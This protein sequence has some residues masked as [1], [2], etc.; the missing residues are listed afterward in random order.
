MVSAAFPVHIHIVRTVIS[1]HSKG[2]SKALVLAS[3]WTG[4]LHVT[5]AVLGTFVLKRFPTSF[6]IGF[7]LGFLVIIA[8]QNLILFG[9]FHGYSLGTGRTNHIFS[10]LALTLFLVLSFFT[11][12]LMNFRDFLVVAAVD[13]KGFGR[14]QQ[15]ADGVFGDE[16]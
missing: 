13:A 14:R 6:A 9:V 5:L 8:N 7:F 15:S 11:A 3:I 4:I 2:S 1:L 10:N 16:Q 12:L